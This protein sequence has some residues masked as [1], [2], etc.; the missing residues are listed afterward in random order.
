M[1]ISY[2]NDLKDAVRAVELGIPVVLVDREDREFEGDL[3]LAA[4]K[5]NFFFL[6]VNI[7]IVENKFKNMLPFFFNEFVF[8]HFVS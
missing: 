1:S 3:V 2:S 6:F 5:V 8:N 7:N 4:E